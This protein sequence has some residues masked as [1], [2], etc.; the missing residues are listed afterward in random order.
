MP[1]AGAGA[2]TVIVPVRSVQVVGLV[3]VAVGAA[4]AVGAAFIVT[5]MQPRYRL[6]HSKLHYNYRGQC[7]EYSRGIGIS[8][9]IDE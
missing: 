5:C 1:A 8:N 2:V 7:S 6:H 4:G 9:A 3:A